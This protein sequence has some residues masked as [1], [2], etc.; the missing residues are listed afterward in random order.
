MNYRDKYIK[1]KTKYIELK[2]IQIGNG[3]ATAKNNIRSYIKKINNPN[4]FNNP[5][6]FKVIFIKN[7]KLT[8]EEEEEEIK[9]INLEN[10]DDENRIEK[11]IKFCI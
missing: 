4:K 5:E 11:K 3:E 9:S 1:Y 2:N 10:T 6:N 8:T 7:L